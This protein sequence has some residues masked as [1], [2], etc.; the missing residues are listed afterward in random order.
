MTFGQKRPDAI[1][2]LV[3]AVNQ[4]LFRDLSS[5]KKIAHVPTVLIV[6]HVIITYESDEGVERGDKQLLA[7]WKRMFE[8]R[9]VP[10]PPRPLSSAITSA[11][12]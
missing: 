2:P 7:G 3:A 9:Q 5:F 8:P 11:D 12:R 4:C 10:S 6:A 1:C